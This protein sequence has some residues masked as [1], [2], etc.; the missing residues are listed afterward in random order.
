MTNVASQMLPSKRI[1]PQNNVTT[2]EQPPGYKTRPEPVPFL[3]CS[4]SCP[5]DNQ[6]SEK[7]TTTFTGDTTIPLLTIA[8]PLIEERLVR[9]AQTNEWYL[10]LT[11]T[12]VLKRKQEMLCVPLDFEDNPTIDALVDSGAYISAIAQMALD[13]IRHKAPSNLLRIGNPALFQV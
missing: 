5:T 1:Q 11:S 6:E 2:T 9:D 12:L 13:T 7:Q 8:T 3:R 4:N 10:P